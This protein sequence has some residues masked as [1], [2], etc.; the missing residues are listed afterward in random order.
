MCSPCSF[1]A[2]GGPVAGGVGESGGGCVRRWRGGSWFGVMLTSGRTVASRTR[3]LRGPTWVISVVQKISESE[4]IF[5]S[6]FLFYRCD[7]NFG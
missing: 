2:A 7:L 4:C 6:G 3:G 1:A 5:Q